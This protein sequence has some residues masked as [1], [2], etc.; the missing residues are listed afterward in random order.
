MKQDSFL[1]CNS[2]PQISTELS[3]AALQVELSMKGP[4]VELVPCQCQPPGASMASR[5]GGASQPHWAYTPGVVH[6][7]G[8]P[9]AR[10][11]DTCPRASAP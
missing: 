6:F 11:C 9:A 5:E 7:A 3:K 8:G 4:S 2:S 1:L 10:S